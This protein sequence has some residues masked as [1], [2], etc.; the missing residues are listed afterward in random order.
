MT[1]EESILNKIQILITNHFE[2]PQKAFE[3]FDTDSD[4]KL[5]KG[6]IVQLLKDAEISGFLRGIVSTKLIEGYDKNGDDLI[7]WEEFKAAIAKIK[8]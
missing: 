1:T 2:T 8:P 6:E 5:T 3:F 7:D 4:G